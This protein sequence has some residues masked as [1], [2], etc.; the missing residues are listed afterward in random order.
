MI[1]AGSFRDPEARV[2]VH[3][4]RVLRGL[5]AKAAAADE[6][7]RNAGVVDRLVGRGL[8][9]KSWVADG[10]E[11]PDGVPSHRVIESERI[12]II[13]YP[14]E[15]SF[16]M[17]RDAALATLE[18][19]LIALESG[20]ILKD[21]SAFNVA[22]AG[23]TPTIIDVTSLDQFGESG[24]WTAYGQ[25]CDHFL[26]P[27]MLESY[28][29][30]PFQSMLRGSVTG[31]SIGDLNRLLRGRSGL[32]RGVLTHV[33][34]RSLLD[35]RGETMDTTTRQRVGSAELPRDAVMGT[36]RK[37]LKLVAGLESTAPSEWA[38]YEDEVPYGTA[39]FERKR[40]FVAHAA[41]ATD[42]RGL[43]ADVGAN[44][45]HFTRVLSEHFDYVVGLDSDPGAVDALYTTAQRAGVADL[46]PMV[47][48]VTNPTPGFGWRNRERAPFAVRVQPDMATWLAVLHHLCLGNGLPLTE[49]VPL[50]YATSPSSVVEF[51]SPDDPM[52][53]HISATRRDELAPYSRQ[54]FEGLAESAGAIAAREELSDTRTI[55][56]LI[57][58]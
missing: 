21:A 9:V 13:S 43:A 49:V 47:V 38:D 39:S 25:F 16:N 53:R 58:R 52:A 56:H 28:A 15:W 3:N 4:G 23:V 11:V 26:A 37:T 50:I 1:E 45:G 42:P 40:A 55:Y 7:A 41:A 35:R 34:L 36:I 27:L 31:V 46:T 10:V 30:V 54:V 18:A 14:V 8:F 6:A 22:F 33:R 24:I 57:G 17:L 2:F 12:P 19:N 48:D 29:G 5:S 51:V 20:F 44:A 32:H